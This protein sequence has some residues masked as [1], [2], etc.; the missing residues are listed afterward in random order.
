MRRAMGFRVGIAALAAGLCAIGLATAQTAQALTVPSEP[1]SLTGTA[2][3]QVAIVKLIWAPPT[4]TGGRVATYLYDVA[5]DYNAGNGTWSVP[6]N[7]STRSTHKRLPCPATFP[8]VCTYRVYAQNKAGTSPPSEPATVPWTVPTK[9]T[10]VSATTTNYSDVSLTWKKPTSSGGLPVSYDLTVSN[11]F[12]ATWVAVAS[13]ITNR[14]YTAAA[15]CTSGFLCLYEVWAKNA[16]GTSPDA[17]QPGRIA[18]APGPVQGLM[19]S[20]SADDPTTGNAA[21]GNGTMNVAWSA[22]LKGLNDGPYELQECP[23]FC[24][25]TDPGWSASVTTPNSTPQLTRT[26]AAGSITCSYRVRATNTRGGWGNWSYRAYLPTA[27]FSVSAATGSTSG[28]IAVTLSGPSIPGSA[29]VT[30]HYA[31]LVCPGGCSLAA[32]WTASSTTSPYPPGSQPFTVDV[33]CPVAD[34]SCKA[35]A[36]FVDDLNATS[37]LSNAATATAA[38]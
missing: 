2:G 29:S 11:D 21:S 36:Q 20:K 25:G 35:R 1:N 26:C 17:P 12:G 32:N 33:A 15:S 16:L 3:P 7:M 31:F 34:A 23:G 24:Y 38:P 5:T 10:T 9:A 27:P 8:A 13:D 19:A 37:M 28:S 4:D 18:V 30:A 22:S 14:S 6:V